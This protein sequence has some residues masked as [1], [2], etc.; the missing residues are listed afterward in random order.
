MV[1][2]KSALFTGN[3][4]QWSQAHTGDLHNK[5]TEG[6]RARGQLD[7]TGSTFFSI[8][9]AAYMSGLVLKNASPYRKTTTPKMEA[10]TNS[11]VY[12]PSHR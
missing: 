9:S 3:N 10:G 6:K 5:G 12:Q 8:T 4:L 11:Q 7:I 2:R 1:A